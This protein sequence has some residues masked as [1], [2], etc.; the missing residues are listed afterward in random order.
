MPVTSNATLEALPRLPEQCEPM[1]N[2]REQV[3]KAVEQVVRLTTGDEKRKHRERI[4][5]NTVRPTFRA[6]KRRDG[7]ES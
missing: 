2:L 4:L 7:A 6:E 5:Q 3:D 1:N